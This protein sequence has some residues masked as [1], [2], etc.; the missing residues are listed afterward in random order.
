MV[1]RTFRGR[2]L[3]GESQKPEMT[4]PLSINIVNQMHIRKDFNNAQTDRFPQRQS[5]L[6]LM[7]KGYRRSQ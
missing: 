5:R 4:V 3:V 7:Q 6:S 1:V 2:P